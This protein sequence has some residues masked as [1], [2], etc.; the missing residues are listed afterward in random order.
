[1]NENAAA[2]LNMLHLRAFL[3]PQSE[4]EEIHWTDRELEEI[5]TAIQANS[6]E[7]ERMQV[8]ALLISFRWEVGEFIAGKRPEV[9]HLS[10]DGIGIGEI[11]DEFL[12]YEQRLLKKGAKT[13]EEQKIADFGMAFPEGGEGPAV[14]LPG[15]LKEMLRAMEQKAKLLVLNFSKSTSFAKEL[16]GTFEYFIGYDAELAPEVAI[17][18]S[19]RFYYYLLR[20]ENDVW[21]AF[22]SAIND[23]REM[24]LEKD[25]YTYSL[26]E[27]DKTPVEDSTYEDSQETE[28]REAQP[29]KAEAPTDGDDPFVNTRLHADHWAE[30]DL[31]GYERYAHNIEQII[32]RKKARPPLTIGIIAPWGQGKTTLMRYVERR[33]EGSTTRPENH[34]K[35]KLNTQASRET[36]ETWSGEDDYQKEKFP[37]YPCVWFNPWQYQSSEQIWA[38]MAHAIIHQ[39][40][41]KL[42]PI[43]QEEFWFKLQS[44]RIDKQA[45]RRDSIRDA[46]TRTIPGM[47]IFVVTAILSALLPIIL[48]GNTG[49]FLLSLG[50]PLSS[51]ILSIKNGLDAYARSFRE[52]Y[53]KYLQSPDY[54]KKLGYF[55]DVN[56]DLQRV[57]DLLVEEDTP[58]LIFIDDLDRCSP[59]KVVEVIEAINL[60]MNASFRKK[61]YFILGMDAEMVAA[62]IDVAY[63]KMQGSIPGKVNKFGSVGWYFLDKFIQLPFLIPTLSD[64]KKLYLVSHLFEEEISRQTP[65]VSPRDLRPKQEEVPITRERFEDLRGKAKS[66]LENPQPKSV[67]PE[68]RPPVVKINNSTERKVFEESFLDLGFEKLEQENEL[69]R[70]V[71]KFAPYLDPS[72]RSIKRFANLL[73]FHAA[74]QK[75]REV[76]NNYLEIEGDTESYEEFADMDTLAFWLILTLRWP[77]LVRWLQWEAEDQLDTD[78]TTDENLM[79]ASN[80][81][82]EKAKMLD[83]LILESLDRAREHGD[84]ELCF[85]KMYSEW[86]DLHKANQHLSWLKDKELLKL[87]FDMYGPEKRLE[88]AFLCAVW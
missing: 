33:F 14:L 49:I 9:V 6:S 64:E 74:L 30:E 55:H 29:E 7:G 84:K 12:P 28:E 57:F 88:R 63:V 16:E 48:P 81:T 54:D 36:I 75:L 15:E 27:G 70:R 85:E 50:V 40:V 69:Q 2:P 19:Q 72:P 78:L 87:F 77:L 43:K 20:F 71:G 76:T 11:S 41:E 18:F 62:S 4:K 22:E 59:Q 38:G 79:F 61:C 65:E 42:S 45:I 34:K 10:G 39:L 46:I 21:K 47:V 32:K 51:V 13:L 8:E 80:Q 35:G 31:L 53:D 52:R 25:G 56:E 37:Q 73:R 23:L 5:H 86:L 44:R 26:F 83:K 66:L 1:M 24:G 3:P 82:R 58:A 17:S 60:M 68:Q 67:N